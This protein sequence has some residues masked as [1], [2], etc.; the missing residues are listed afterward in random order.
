MIPVLDIDHLCLSYKDTPILKDICLKVH[1]GE[2]LAV[3]GPNGCGKTTLV[4][5]ILRSI[6]PGAGQIRFKGNDITAL[7]AKALAKGMAS[8]LQ[9]I[10]PAAMTVKEYVL[11]GRLPYFSPYQFF[12]T[13]KDL[14]IAL[15]YMELTGT[16]HL[17]DARIN[18][19][20]GGERQLAAI[21]RA[22]TQEPSLIIM[23]EPTSNL[24]ITHQ[25]RVLD[26]MTGLKEDL[27]VTI[28]MVLHDLNLAA[29]YADRLVLL[30]KTDGRVYGSGRPLDVLTEEA[31]EAV[32][33]TKVTVAPNPVTQN[34]FV[35]IVKKGN[36]HD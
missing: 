28:L 6:T 16:A 14:D 7:P 17:C 10:D 15:K 1:Q 32:Y 26:L 18:E 4:K 34:P 3:V 21:A 8:V 35:F 2:F 19:I 36:T 30:N 9:T 24:D 33:Q 23:D 25:V 29:E 31:I 20:S 12:E 13:R 11:L 5:A 27:G 22:L